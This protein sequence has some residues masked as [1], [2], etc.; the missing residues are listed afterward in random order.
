MVR[1]LLALA[2]ALAAAPASDGVSA[3]EGG[4]VRSP[5]RAWTIVVPAPR[6]D[7]EAVTATA[8]LNGP[9]VRGRR[10]MRFERHVSAVWPRGSGKVVLVEQTMH[11]AR[12]EVFTLGPR[13]TAA[14]DRIQADVVRG[15]AHQ[16]PRIAQ[17]ENRLVAFGKAGAATCVLVEES[18]LPPGRDEGS[19]VVRRAAFRLD[20][21]AKRAVPVPT[22]PGAAIG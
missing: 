22:C 13:E 6:G 20:L 18:G 9:G 3:F 14:P 8:W 16:L 12:V 10:L 21:A 4:Q 11:F 15:M 17:I 7:S 5:D 2:L 19:F 1:P